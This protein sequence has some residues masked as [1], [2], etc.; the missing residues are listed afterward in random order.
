[1][2]YIKALESALG[3]TAKKN[4]LPM[5]S[6]DVPVTAANTDELEAWIGFKPNTAV[7]DG[8]R[9]FVDWYLSYYKV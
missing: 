6:G 2:D 9:L 5:Q 8:V 4:Y 3:V 1:M 7:N